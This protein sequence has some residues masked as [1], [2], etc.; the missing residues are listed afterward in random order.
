M[1][2][3]SNLWQRTRG[4]PVAQAVAPGPTSAEIV[5]A[6]DPLTAYFNE[7]FAIMQQTLT[8]GAMQKVMTKLWKETLG[9][10]EALLIPPLSDK[11]SGQKPMNEQELDIVYK[12]LDHLYDFFHAEGEGVAAENLR[13]PKYVD[14]KNLRFFYDQPT[15]QLIIE[16]DRM[17]AA[18]LQRQR[19]AQQMGNRVSAPAAMAGGPSA[20]SGLLGVSSARRTQS[21]MLNRNLGTM[22]KAKEDKR[23]EAQAEQSDD[24]LLR[25]LRMRPEAEKY[26]KDRSRQKQKL[27]TKAAADQMILQSMA[28]G[29][30][31]G[32][33]LRG[34]SNH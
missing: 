2:T 8:E 31:L 30:A 26:L 27:A 17:A 24:I 34:S 7:N 12:W 21:I 32:L 6:L 18:A 22:R 29:A 14:L 33:H 19:E 23:R 16:S 4:Q 13:S 10:L 9:S 15:Q 25:I 5:A 28:K 11:P 20:S 3:V 1:T